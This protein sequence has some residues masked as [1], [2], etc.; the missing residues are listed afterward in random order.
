M[1]HSPVIE[2]FLGL[3]IKC[4]W[5]WTSTLLRKVRFFKIWTRRQPPFQT[6]RPFCMYFKYSAR[7]HSRPNSGY[8]YYYVQFS[9]IL[10]QKIKYLKNINVLWWYFILYFYITVVQWSTVLS[11]QSFNCC[12]SNKQAIEFL[13]YF[14]LFL[15][16]C[17]FTQVDREAFSRV[18]GRVSWSRDVT[19]K[20]HQTRKHFT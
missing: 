14:I 10:S 12:W 20:T 7:G 17:T 19:D 11:Q 4:W 18:P 6:L 1:Y 8:T 5:T 15:T 13:H 2:R 3:V 9:T 16:L